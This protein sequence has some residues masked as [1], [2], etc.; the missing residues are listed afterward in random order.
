[1]HAWVQVL[2]AVAVILALTAVA[3]RVVRVESLADSKLAPTRQQDAMIL[4]APTSSEAKIGTS[5]STHTTKADTIFDLQPPNN[6]VGGDQFSLSFRLKLKDANKLTN[7]C[8][9]LWGDPNYVK[10]K[11]SSIDS[12]IKHLLV[13]MPMIWLST[14]SGDK[15]LVHA[16]DVNFNG[17]GSILNVCSGVIE[18]DDGTRQFDIQKQGVMI[19]VTFA[20]YYV[21]E[22]TRG[23][24]CNLYVNTRLAGSVKVAGDSIRRNPGLMYILP[25]VIDGISDTRRTSGVDNVEVSGLS[26]HNYELDIA[27]I[28]KKVRGAIVY[29]RDVKMSGGG[30]AVYDATRDLSYHGLVT[31]TLQ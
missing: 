2:L 31:P 26:Y 28:E 1:M 9:L 13:F 6:R 5:A 16:V 11:S 20:D 10:F 15:G 24:L 19:T 18:N 27:T 22:S 17:T 23:C 3:M 14:S 30:G 7:R 25:S 12:T 4:D 21:N 8:L 29:T